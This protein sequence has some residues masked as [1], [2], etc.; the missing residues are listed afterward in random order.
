MHIVYLKGKRSKHSFMPYGNVSRPGSYGSDFPLRKRKYV[1]EEALRFT[2]RYN[3]LKA[4]LRR[5]EKQNYE[6]GTVIFVPNWYVGY[7]DVAVIV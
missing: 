5:I 2:K 7:A 3:S 4:I 6:K 1:R